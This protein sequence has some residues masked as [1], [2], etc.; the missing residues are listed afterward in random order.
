MF[1]LL[2]GDYTYTSLLGKLFIENL[3]VTRLSHKQ[4]HSFG[5]DAEVLRPTA[6]AA[7]SEVLRFTLQAP[8]LENPRILRSEFHRRNF[9]AFVTLPPYTPDRMIVQRLSKPSTSCFWPCVTHTGNA[10]HSC[11]LNSNRNHTPQYR[12][13]NMA[14][15]EL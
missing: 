14:R 5:F 12:I 15:F 3:S 1:Y 10:H 11:I 4:C 9:N 6:A 8:K 13:P 2:K 7:H